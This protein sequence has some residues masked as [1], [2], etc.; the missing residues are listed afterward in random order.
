M[1][2]SAETIAI[3]S[4]ERTVVDL[5]R[6]RSRVG[7]DLALSALRRYLEGRDAK[8]G[9]LLALARQLRVGTVIAEVMEPMLA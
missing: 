5:L 7:R 6:L 8:P 9:E 3:S 4:Q 2:E 1:L